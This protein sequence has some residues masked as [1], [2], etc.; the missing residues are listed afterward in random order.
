VCIHPKK[1]GWHNRRLN[2]SENS[3]VRF[4]KEFDFQAELRLQ[5]RKAGRSMVLACGNDRFA[6]SVRADVARNI[7]S[8]P[9]LHYIKLEYRPEEISSLTYDRPELFFSDVCKWANG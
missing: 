1:S 7:K 2:Q 3:H 5:A 9:G 4:A 6:A 8:T